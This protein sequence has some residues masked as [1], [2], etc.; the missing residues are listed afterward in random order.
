ML[1]AHKSR[2]DLWAIFFETVF[3]LEV[4]LSIGTKV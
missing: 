4:F 3:Y 2:R 1:I